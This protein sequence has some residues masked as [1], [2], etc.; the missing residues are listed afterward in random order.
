MQLETVGREDVDGRL[1]PLAHEALYLGVYF[2]S[3]ALGARKLGAAAKVLVA[4]LAQ[5][6]H[7][8]LVRHAVLRHHGARDLRG[9][10]DVV[11]GAGGHLAKDELLG[12]AAATE[13]GNL[14]LGLVARGEEVLVLLNLHGEAEGTRGARHDGDLRDGSGALLGCGNNGV[15]GLVVGHDLLLMF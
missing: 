13:R 7:A 10:L 8:K 11:G 15:A 2:S 1:V 12:C 9:L 6:N 5:G 4:L 14:L 3:R